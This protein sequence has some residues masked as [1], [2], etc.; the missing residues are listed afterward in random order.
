MALLGKNRRSCNVEGLGAE[1]SFGFGLGGG[2]RWGRGGGPAASLPLRSHFRR[3]LVI[4]S[5]AAS[6]EGSLPRLGEN[7]SAADTAPT[8]HARQ[9]GWVQM[10]SIQALTP[11]PE[12]ICQTA[13]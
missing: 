8:C 10:T 1:A 2:G 7:Q 11:R 9:L 5:S 12:A 3:Q 4:E 13:R 6:C